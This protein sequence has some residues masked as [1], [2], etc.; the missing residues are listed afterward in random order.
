MRSKYGRE[1]GTIEVT[2]SGGGR[3][4]YSVAD[5]GPGIPLDDQ[6]R[7]FERFYRVSGSGSAGSGLGLAIARALVELH[8]GR[9]WVESAP[10][11]G[12]TFRIALPIE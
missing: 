9:L 4:V 8:G 7:I 2:S 12:S 5:D 6:E 10:G 1:R 11:R 3:G